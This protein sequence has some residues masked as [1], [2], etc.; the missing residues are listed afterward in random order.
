VAQV[1][2]HEAQPRNEFGEVGLLDDEVH[3]LRGAIEIG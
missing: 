3:F 1:V 2:E